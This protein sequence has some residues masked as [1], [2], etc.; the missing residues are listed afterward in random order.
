M[1]IKYALNY[2]QH[3]QFLCTFEQEDDVK[4]E[5]LLFRTKMVLM[6]KIHFKTHMSAEVVETF[7]FIIYELHG[8]WVKNCLYLGMLSILV[9]I[10]THFR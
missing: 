4:I 9:Q 3:V 1:P 7:T 5:K 8:K 10:S 6:L 2:D